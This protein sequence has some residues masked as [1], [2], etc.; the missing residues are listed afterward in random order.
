VADAA[1]DGT[2]VEDGL[3]DSEPSGPE[4]AL[5]LFVPHNTVRTH[6]RHIFAKLQVTARRAAVLRAKN[7][8][9]L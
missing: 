7:L 1:A 5:A 3:L 9:F 4:I 8:E 6:T 2:R